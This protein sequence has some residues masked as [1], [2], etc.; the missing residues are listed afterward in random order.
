MTERKA[1]NLGKRTPILPYK[2]S[3]SLLFVNVFSSSG[4]T[5]MKWAGTFLVLIWSSVYADTIR[6]SHD[7]SGYG[8]GG[9]YSGTTVC[10]TEENGGVGGLAAF[11]EGFSKGV[12]TN[13]LRRQATEQ[14]EAGIRAEEMHELKMENARLK[15]EVLRRQ[16]SAA[17]AK[18]PA[19][20]PGYART[21]KDKKSGRS[22][23]AA[24][25]F[26]KARRSE[27]IGEGA[28]RLTWEEQGKLVRWLEGNTSPN[29]EISDIFAKMAK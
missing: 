19:R 22:Q 26:E 20:A 13:A 1:W 5:V 15:N 12:A 10:N 29:A 4:Q 21:G 27:I 25:E 7:Y 18:L 8:F 14:H 17:P 24:I 6:C 3:E 11:A 2:A 16:L 9:G 23:T 28:N